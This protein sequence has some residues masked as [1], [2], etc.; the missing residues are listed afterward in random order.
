MDCVVLI[1]TEKKVNK[2][3]IVNERASGYRDVGRKGCSLFLSFLTN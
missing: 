3:K 1:S 2:V